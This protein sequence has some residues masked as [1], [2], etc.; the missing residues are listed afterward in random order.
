LTQ[1]AEPG[2]AQARRVCLWSHLFDG[3]A[4]S[5]SDTRGHEKIHISP[6]FFASGK[7]CQRIWSKRKDGSYADAGKR[8]ARSSRNLE[9][10]VPRWG[11]VR[12]G[13]QGRFTAYFQRYAL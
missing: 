5:S 8:L 6:L 7:S 11:S 2:V 9:R 4:S 12:W 3:T 1:T 10:K 13:N